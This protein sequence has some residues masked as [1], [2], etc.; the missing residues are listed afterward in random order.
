MAIYPTG[1]SARRSAGGQPYHRVVN[2]LPSPLAATG[3]VFRLDRKMTT[4]I[5]RSIA[6]GWSAFARSDGQDLIVSGP[7][8]AADYETAVEDTISAAQEALDLIAA[9]GGHA[10]TIE[11]TET[12]HIVWWTE[13]R[14]I[15]LRDMAISDFGLSFSGTAEVLDAAGNLV[16]QPAPPPVPWHESFRYF[17]ISQTTGDLFDAY[18]NLYLAVE[19]LLSTVVRM[20]LNAAGLPAEG[21]GQWLRRA[22]TQIHPAT[23]DLA[24]YTVAG[25]ANPVDAVYNDLYAGM[26]TQLFHSKAG[27]PTLLPTRCRDGKTS[28]RVLNV[29]VV[30]MSTSPDPPF[31]FSEARV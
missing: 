30:C 24:R 26:R 20:H 17:R 5:S 11:G 6:G 15:V 18:R 21:E 16:T 9:E 29:S 27:R 10:L 19:S 23:V 2:L 13:S 7:Q 31:R 25:V 14:G 1:R 4:D 12:G 22:L 28:W 3:G 8:G